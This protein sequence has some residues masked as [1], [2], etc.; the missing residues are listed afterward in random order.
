VELTAASGSDSKV[1]GWLDPVNLAHFTSS[2]CALREQFVRELGHAFLTQG[3]VFL[4]GHGLA[5]EFISTYYKTAGRVL[6]EIPEP[7]LRAFEFVKESIDRGYVSSPSGAPK[8]TVVCLQKAPQVLVAAGLKF[9]FDNHAGQATVMVSAGGEKASYTLP[10]AVYDPT[11][12]STEVAAEHSGRS[13]RFRRLDFDG[14]YVVFT[15]DDKHGWITGVDHNVFPFETADFAL[16]S[17]ELCRV[18]TAAGILMI[19]ALG[20]FLNDHNDVLSRLVADAAGNNI[21][22]HALRTYR[23][24]AIAEDELESIP[25]DAHFVRVGE[26]RDISLLTILPKANLPGLQIQMRD[27]TWVD[28]R[29]PHDSVVVMAGEMLSHMTRGLRSENGESREIYAPLH[30]V[31]GD[32][33]NIHKDRYTAPFFFNAD[34]RQ[35]ILNLSDREPVTIRNVR[36]EPG[37]RLLHS[38]MRASTQFSQ[39]SFEDFAADYDQLG[40]RLQK[41]LAMRGE[42]Q[43]RYIH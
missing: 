19:R 20:R 43:A 34:L 6:R 29:A 31:M 28:V 4:T 33:T 35:P 40:R 1:T 3:F 24:P 11:H 38:H 10:S 16:M 5:P 42:I 9:I 25:G 30:R 26:H 22:A 7:R 12:S 32:R 27:Q 13:L 39:R 37:L 41:A 18:H 2:N 21:A 23:Y 36:L 17:L 8:P 14:N 15:P